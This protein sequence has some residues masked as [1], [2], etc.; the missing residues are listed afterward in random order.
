M[1]VLVTGASGVFG[2]EI[3]QRLVAG[4]HE[5]VGT[6]RRVP[7]GLPAGVRHVVADIT[8][9]DALGR[10]I[11]GCD[12][13][14]HC[15]WAVGALHDDDA[16]RHINVGG[17]EAVLTAMAWVGARRIV[18]ASSSTA[19]GPRPAGL[20]VDEG[21]PLEPHP[22]HTYAVHKAEVEAL[23]AG[24]DVDAV[25][26]RSAVVLGRHIDNRIWS[27]MAAPVQVDVKG[28]PATWQV[29]HADDVGR[30]FVQC[31]EGGPT[32]AVNLAAPGTFTAQDLAAAFD[33]RLVHVPERV[34]R[35]GVQI[36]WDRQ[37]FDVS[38]AEVDFIVGMPIMDT[39]RLGDAFGFSCAWT[40]HEAL[41]D[42]RLAVT[43]IVV[44]GPKVVE[45]PWRT[46]YE[47][48]PAVRPQGGWAAGVRRV[49]RAA[50]YGK[51]SQELALHAAR[52]ER[53]AGDPT[54][55]DDARLTA[56]IDLGADLVA[57]GRGSV[58][59]PPSRRPVAH[60]RSLASIDR[61]TA[62]LRTLEQERARRAADGL[63]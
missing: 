33:R 35:R 20:G 48:S 60:V 9:A 52:L 26:I 17:T 47:R 30:F 44:A 25:S 55:L 16:E 56:L 61:T 29:V 38:P 62:V 36:L 34:L 3:V 27:F 21:T 37:A 6:S 10:A 2:R 13:V 57:Y 46:R 59:R 58:E 24:T 4:G 14:A 1:R 42:T 8:D 41:E 12:V 18:F 11:D 19:Y 32:G 50:G 22:G 31:C 5:V 63:S 28:R 23:L 53:L 54:S 45:L 43:G 49:G 15:A 39:A 51:D 40:A 7:D